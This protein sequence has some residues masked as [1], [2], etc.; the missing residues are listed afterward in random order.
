MGQVGFPRGSLSASPAETTSLNQKHWRVG[1]IGTGGR[2]SARPHSPWTARGASAPPEV[3]RAFTVLNV[4]SFLHMTPILL[5]SATICAVALTERSVDHLIFAIAAFSCIAAILLLIVADLE[6]ATLLATILAAAIVGASKV[7]Y[8]H[9]GI[10]LTMA[11]L[12]LA[13]AGTAPF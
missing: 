6:R 7:K 9:S 8:H 5:W 2:S 12:P 13:F 4:G 1:E 11:D 3:G 10:K